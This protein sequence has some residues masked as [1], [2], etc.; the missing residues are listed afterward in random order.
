MAKSAAKQEAQVT[1]IAEAKPKKK[2][3]LLK[4]VIALVVLTGGA[5]VAWYAMQE[6]AAAPETAAAKE[7]PPVFVPLESFIVNLQPENGD[8]YLQVGLV[9]KVVE[10]TT[11]DSIKQQMPEI[12]NRILLLLSSKKASEISTLAGKQQLITEVMN[13]VRQPLG[14]EKLQQGIIGVFFTSFVI[15]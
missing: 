3:R 13:E 1:P 8:Q 7:K 15:Q 5:G 4:I 2:G 9:V 12:R 14:S 10:A 11:T 6:P